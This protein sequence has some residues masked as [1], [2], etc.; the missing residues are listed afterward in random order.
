[1]SNEAEPDDAP[2]KLEKARVL[3]AHVQAVFAGKLF[4]PHS[5]FRGGHAQTIAAYAWPRR[6]RF[7]TEKDEER[8]FEVEPGV[9]VLAHCRWQTERD[10]HPT[11]VVWHGIEGSTA[12]N[13]M[14][15]MAE[16]GFR[17]GFNV[18]RVNFRNCGG[19][20]HLTET[21]YHGGLSADLAAVV[22]ELLEKDHISRLFLAGFSLGGNLVL[23]LA[24]EYGDNP[25]PQILGVC[26][27]SPSV[28]LSASADMILKRSNWLYHRDFVRRLKQRIRTNNKLYPGSYD[29]SGLDAVRTLREFDD[30][31]TAVA[32][33]FAD[34]NDYYHRSSS[35]RVID[36]I[37]IPTLIIHA[38]DDPFIPVA[39]LRDP[40]VADNHYI[41]LFAPAQGGHVAFIADDPKDDVDRFWAENR[42]V[43]FCA[44]VV[45]D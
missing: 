44:L 13:Y 29:I 21:I 43:E 38:A 30:H 27:V 18:I 10:S 40:A 42:V 17:A 16:K 25:P 20:E 35:L 36:R 6:F 37:R 32:H 4:R 22:R 34:A 15:A 1:M 7:A 45:A 3:L 31:Y 11:I 26:A 28:D 12:S 41:L 24:G 14:Q 33:G 2:Q 8:L 23:K 9:R 39:P 19:T 5:I